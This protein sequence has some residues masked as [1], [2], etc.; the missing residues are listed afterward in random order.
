LHKT[1]TARRDELRK[2]LGIDLRDLAASA[3]GDV[4]ETAFEAE[5]IELAGT[6]ASFE[7]KELDR[8]ERALLRL[9]SGRFGKCEG[10]SGKIPVARLNFMPTV[11][12]CIACQRESEKDSTW[13]Q[14]RQ[15]ERQE[16]FE[17]V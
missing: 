14:D 11:E 1:L 6:L 10:C 9:K 7:A 5:G 8:V 15:L 13:L 16:L 4:A 12:L 2:R 17:F 3:D